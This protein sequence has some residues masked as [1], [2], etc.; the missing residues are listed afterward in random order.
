MILNSFFE[1]RKKIDQKQQQ[2]SIRTNDTIK[3]EFEVKEKMAQCGKNI[4]KMNEYLKKNRSKDQGLFEKR[5]KIYDSLHL[6][7]NTFNKMLFNKSNG[8][9]YEE[10]GFSEPAGDTSSRTGRLLGA[11]I[12]KRIGGGAAR[13]LTDI[14]KDGMREIEERDRQTDELVD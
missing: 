9:D 5:Q 13:E 3:L 14:E 7:Y 2:G 8:A 1:I 6:Q 10:S 11:P 4:S 12:E